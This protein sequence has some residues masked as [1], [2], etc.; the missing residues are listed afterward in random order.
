MRTTLVLNDELAMA[1]KQ[2][3]A[4]KQ[5]SLSG[6]VNMALRKALA[7][8]SAKPAAPNFVM[9]VFAGPPGRIADTSPEELDAF[10]NDP[11]PAP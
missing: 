9:P 10:L 5:T 4:R 1:A 2:L 7:D 6:L 3:A 11:V 8:E